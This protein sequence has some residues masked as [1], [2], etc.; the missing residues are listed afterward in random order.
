M[1]GRCSSFLLHWWAH[2]TGMQVARQARREWV[3]SM[4]SSPLDPGRERSIPHPKERETA[5]ERKQLSLR[6][7][8]ELLWLLLLKIKRADISVSAYF[9]DE[10]WALSCHP[11]QAPHYLLF[12]QLLRYTVLKE[13][14]LLFKATI[15]SLAVPMTMPLHRK[16]GGA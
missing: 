6:E 1:A 7:K 2:F 14:S 4:A 3:V 11:P 12:F 16:C 13:I 15:H 5:F 10:D 9:L 8:L